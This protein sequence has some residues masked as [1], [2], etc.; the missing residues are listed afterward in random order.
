MIKV[1][2]ATGS[3]V[4]IAQLFRTPTVAGLAEALERLG[5]GRAVSVARADFSAEQ[6]AAGVPCSANQ[7][8]MLVL[9]QMQPD[10]AGYNMAEVLR[11][12]APVDIDVLQARACACRTHTHT[13]GHAEGAALLS[14]LSVLCRPPWFPGTPARVAVHARP[15]PRR[16]MALGRATGPCASLWHTLT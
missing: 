12:R 14:G 9:Y 10:S 2:Q 15:G 7:E 5:L 11:L 3:D 13:R 8:Q 1:R 16:R 4:P 6:R